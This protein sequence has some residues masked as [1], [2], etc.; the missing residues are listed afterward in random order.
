MYTMCSVASYESEWKSHYSPVIL[1]LYLHGGMLVNKLSVPLQPETT[2]CFHSIFRF[3]LCCYCDNLPE[4]AKLGLTSSPG[5]G[6]VALYTVLSFEFDLGSR[7]LLDE[8]GRGL[9]NPIWLPVI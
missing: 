1:L 2:T 8:R 6:R 9:V 7:Q 4:V 5:E 3:W